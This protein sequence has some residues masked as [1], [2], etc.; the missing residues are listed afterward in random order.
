MVIPLNWGMQVSYEDEIRIDGTLVKEKT[1]RPIYLALNKPVGIECTTN[2]EVTDNIID[3][4]NYPTRI[5]PIGRLDKA[6]E[7]L[8]FLT[9]DGEIVNINP[10]GKKQSRKRVRCN[11]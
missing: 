11:G 1:T 8:I 3:F 4:V 7:G 9:D 2:Q 5:F 6:S 10:S